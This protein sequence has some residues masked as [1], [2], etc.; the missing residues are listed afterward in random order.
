MPAFMGAWVLLLLA[1]SGAGDEVTYLRDLDDL[2]QIAESIGSAIPL[3]LAFAED[4]ASVEAGVFHEAAG[5][6]YAPNVRFA[7]TSSEEVAAEWFPSGGWT[8][9][10]VLIINTWDFRTEVPL[11]Q[12]TEDADLVTAEEMSRFIGMHAQESV[13]VFDFDS[14]ILT[15]DATPLDEHSCVE[16]PAEAVVRLQISLAQEQPAYNHFLLGFSDSKAKYGETLKTSL[17]SAAKHFRMKAAFLHINTTGTPC[18]MAILAHFGVGQ[19]FDESLPTMRLLVGNETEKAWQIYPSSAAYPTSEEKV[20]FP[21]FLR[22]AEKAAHYT[23]EFVKALT[24]H[25][26]ESDD[27]TDDEDEIDEGGEP[28]YRHGASLDGA[29]AG[30]GDN[31][32]YQSMEEANAAAAAAA[33][34]FESVST[35]DLDFEGAKDVYMEV[36]DDIGEEL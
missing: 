22:H 25:Y 3:A 21:I 20:L 31:Y 13:N 17:G 28:E 2:A 11:Y 30:T 26:E 18:E 23:V 9:F 27:V 16:N 5:L 24:G 33:E 15:A 12:N 35:K 19:N 14:R 36:A 32:V 7:I 4:P 6:K 10:R 29:G 34:E 8:P 1:S